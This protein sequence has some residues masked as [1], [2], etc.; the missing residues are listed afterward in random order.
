MAGLCSR[1]PAGGVI[2]RKGIQK[3][4]AGAK[5][6]GE[7]EMNTHSLGAGRG[8]LLV[9]AVWGGPSSGALGPFP[10]DGEINTDSANLRAGPSLN[11]EVAH[12][13]DRGAPVLVTGHRRGW[14]RVESP[15]E[16]IFYVSARYLSD[17][18]VVCGRLNVRVEPSPSA[19]VVCQL[20]RGEQV[21]EI[22]RDGEWAAIKAP[23]CAAL[24]VRAE[25]ITVCSEETRGGGVSAAGRRVAVRTRA[26]PDARAGPVAG[27]TR[28][29]PD[30]RPGPV[31]SAP[32]APSKRTPA[33]LASRPH[34]LPPD[35]RAGPHT[36]AAQTTRAAASPSELVRSPGRPRRPRRRPNP[37]SA[38]T[39]APAAPPSEP[40]A[41]SDACAGRTAARTRSPPRHPR[42]AAS[43][44]RTRRSP[45][46][47]RRP[48]RRPNPRCRPDTLGPAAPPPAPA[49]EETPEPA[50]GT[51]STRVA[52]RP[53]NVPCRK[54]GK[55]VRAD[56]RGMRGAPYC[57]VDGF[58]VR[59][60]VALVD[61]N[62]VNLGHYEGDRVK[63]W[64]YERFRD[65][66]GVPVVDVRRLE[67]E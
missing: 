38:R 43:P 56:A 34:P 55:L 30:A 27:R 42:P 58:F 33:P 26:G 39:P 19:T 13:L 12:R 20:V 15:E 51:A 21:E 53:E 44:V 6:R 10:C 31:P 4:F 2:E 59:R 54:R 49:S 47:P 35:A 14:Y 11:Y 61:S 9:A 40:R 52:A 64:G 41:V 23:D 29:R 28:G 45:R 22:E 16:A 60:V 66:A 8:G 48:H 67:V 62:T 37:R 36:A 63:V 3:L 7:G 57:L 1:L 32:A 24:W 5:P 18:A 17:G 65:P 25:L 50:A 46:H